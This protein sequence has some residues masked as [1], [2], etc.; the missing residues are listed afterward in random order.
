M[1]LS[2]EDKIY[3]AYKRTKSA[4]EKEGLLPGIAHAR[5]VLYISE[6]FS[7]SPIRVMQIVNPRK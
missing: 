6:V 7:L 1:A 2:R 5:S 3:L 4:A